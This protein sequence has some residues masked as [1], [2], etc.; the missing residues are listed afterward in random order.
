MLCLALRLGH[1]SIAQMLLSGGANVNSYGPDENLSLLQLFI[2]RRDQ[3]VALFLIENGAHVNSETIF[4][5]SPLVLS[6]H[7]DLPD[8]LEELCRRGANMEVV[9]G[10]ESPLWLALAAGKEDLASILVRY[11]NVFN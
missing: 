11:F 7:Q 2:Q 10:D 8:V 3:R 5:Q 9:P 1:F 6:I 4:D